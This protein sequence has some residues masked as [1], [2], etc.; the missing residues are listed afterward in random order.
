MV[1][2]NDLYS[3]FGAIPNNRIPAIKGFVMVFNQD[4]LAE[5]IR[6]MN[7][8]PAIVLVMPGAKTTSRDE[9]N[10]VDGS[11]CLLFVLKK[12]DLKNLATNGIIN[13]MDYL[14]NDVEKLKQL[15]VDDMHNHDTPGH[16]MHDLDPD[17]MT[18]EPE[19]NY[20]GCY[21]WSLAFMIN[22]PGFDVK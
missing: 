10:I 6:N 1:R 22:R 5:H 2:V 13:E 18:T 19:Y 16:L 14:Q 3:Y 7:L 12:L 11:E 4:D 15:M 21:G 9:D 20:L 17:G 8:F